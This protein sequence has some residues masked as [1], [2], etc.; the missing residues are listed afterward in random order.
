MLA[1]GRVLARLPSKEKPFAF[2]TLHIPGKTVSGCTT[3][4]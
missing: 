4:K 3:L 1:E 2:T